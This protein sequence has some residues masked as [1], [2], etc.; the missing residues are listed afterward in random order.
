MC[1]IP[2]SCNSNR[3][4]FLLPFLVAFLELA[5]AKAFKSE[6]RLRGESLRGFSHRVR[7]LGLR[8]QLF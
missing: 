4:L 8:H 3:V 2:L 5:R 6:A 1:L 7:N